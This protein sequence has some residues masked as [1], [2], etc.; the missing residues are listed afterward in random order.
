[1]VRTNGSGQASIQV[2]A[3]AEPGDIGI[4]V[5]VLGASQEVTVEVVAQ[6]VSYNSTIQPIFTSRCTSC[7]DPTT[8]NAGGLDLRSY[9]GLMAGGNS[10]AEV[11]PGAASDS[12]L[13]ARIEGTIPPQMPLGQDP[14]TQAQIQSIRTWIDQGALNN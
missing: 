11:I 13:V 1:V 9:Q 8:F 2:T 10:G 3:G 4:T 14:L 7:H 12:R 6:Q 5:Q